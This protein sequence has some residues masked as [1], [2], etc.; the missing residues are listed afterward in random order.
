MEILFFVLGGNEISLEFIPKNLFYDY[1]KLL[2][3]VS[4]FK[5]FQ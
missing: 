1:T 2:Q 5:K 4:Q 3:V